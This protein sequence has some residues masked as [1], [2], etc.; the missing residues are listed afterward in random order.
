LNPSALI[1]GIG[2]ATCLQ[3]SGPQ[4]LIRLVTQRKHVGLY[5]T[6]HR[7]LSSA[8]QWIDEAS[9]KGYTITLARRRSERTR[10][11][12]QATDN[13]PHTRVVMYV[14]RF[15]LF[16]APNSFCAAPLPLSEP[17]VPASGRNEWVFSNLGSQ[18]AIEPGPGI[19]INLEDRGWRIEELI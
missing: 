11:C 18:S 14:L 6:V 4:A 8:M 17:C 13:A 10:I 19:Q 3:R 5:S 15:R 7:G 12:L 9:G 2:K 1:S 16:N